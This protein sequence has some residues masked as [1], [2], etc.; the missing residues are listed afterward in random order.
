MLVT[1][2]IQGN[3]EENRKPL[4]VQVGTHHTDATEWCFPGSHR[5][6][7]QCQLQ[8]KQHRLQASTAYVSILWQICHLGSDVTLL[9]STYLLISHQPLRSQCPQV[10]F[11]SCERLLHLSGL[12]LLLS[13]STV[14]P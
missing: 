3:A 13:T 9:T 11:S 8:K 2:E 5:C 10:C 6:P 7:L 12:V 4:S 14:D 1:L